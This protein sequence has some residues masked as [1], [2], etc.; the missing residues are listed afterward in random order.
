[1]LGQA[2]LGADIEQTTQTEGAIDGVRSDIP[3]A[4]FPCSN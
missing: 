2:R 3:L 1:V 4:T